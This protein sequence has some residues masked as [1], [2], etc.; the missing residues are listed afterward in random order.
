M[1]KIHFT[2]V[3]ALVI[4]VLALNA[5]T[6]TSAKTGSATLIVTGNVHSQLDPCG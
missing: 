2:L 3:G 5:C 4:A 6:K 1:K